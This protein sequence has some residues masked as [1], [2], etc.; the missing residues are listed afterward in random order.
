MVVA[1]WFAWEAFGYRPYGRYGP[2]EPLL[3][4]PALA[5]AVPALLLLATADGE[6]RSALA[7]AAVVVLPI[8]LFIVMSLIARFSSE[9]FEHLR[10]PSLEWQVVLMV[11]GAVTLLVAVALKLRD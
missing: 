10:P 4:V 2:M 3:F 9:I 5:L 1:A 7:M 11:A 8:T 6:R